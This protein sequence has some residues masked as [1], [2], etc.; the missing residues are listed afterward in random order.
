M[1][2][3]VLLFIV[4]GTLGGL[5]HTVID[6]QGWGDLKKFSSFKTVIIGAIV[7]FLYN[8]LHSDYSFPNGVM[9]FV[10]GYSGVDFLTKLLEKRRKKNS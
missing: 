4:M 8:Y 3:T 1:D 6:A 2:V 10:S 5:A 9:S 7:G